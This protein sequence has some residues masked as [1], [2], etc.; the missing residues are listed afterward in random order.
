MKM[1][2]KM[3]EGH[4]T[5]VEDIH[6]KSTETH[7]QKS[8]GNIREFPAQGPNP[9][10]ER[11]LQKASLKQFLALEYGGRADQSAGFAHY[12]KAMPPRTI[13]EWRAAFDA[14]MKRPIK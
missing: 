10:L 11:V 14:F 12:A 1:K 9:E 8:D 4:N 2:T 7:T 5:L 6:Q 13:P 3:P